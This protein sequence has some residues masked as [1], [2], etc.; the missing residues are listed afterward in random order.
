MRTPVYLLVILALVN[1]AALL[2]GL[3]T[4]MAKFIERQFSQTSALSN[5]MIGERPSPSSS[6]WAWLQKVE[7]SDGVEISLLTCLQE[8]FVSHWQSWAP[9]WEGLWCEGWNFLWAAPASCARAPSLSAC[10]PPCRCCWSAAPPRRSMES[11]LLGNRTVRLQA[12]S[13]QMAEPQTPPPTM[14]RFYPNHRWRMFPNWGF[15]CCV[16]VFSSGSLSC[17]SGCHCPQGAF[18][19]VCASNLV[20]FRSP[21]HAGCNGI[22]FGSDNKPKVGISLTEMNGFLFGKC[23]QICSMKANPAPWCTMNSTHLIVYRKCNR[24]QT[25]PSSWETGGR[26][27]GTPHSHYSE[28]HKNIQTW[29]TSPHFW[30]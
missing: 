20:E 5:M 16:F 10:S 26:L 2:A 6:F 27:P 8:E 25:Q 28:K 4:F 17:S 11:F 13:L 21:C 15:P 12:P 22:E 3:A 7:E 1:Q 23:G 19:P 29:L 9:S 24:F 30:L 14:N 18:N